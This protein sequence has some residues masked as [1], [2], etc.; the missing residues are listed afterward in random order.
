VTN[1]E[2]SLKRSGKPPM[3]K[4]NRM[5]RVA[6]RLLVSFV[7]WDTDDQSDQTRGVSFD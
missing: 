3:P 4:G 7:E 1:Q 2:I 5:W 6:T